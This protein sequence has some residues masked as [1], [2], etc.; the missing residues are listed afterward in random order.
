M[1]CN[2]E[3][4]ERQQMSSWWR[5]SLVPEGGMD[6]IFFSLELSVV[7]SGFYKMGLK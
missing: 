7:S 4:L 2:T 1:G 3:D 5:Q 6:M